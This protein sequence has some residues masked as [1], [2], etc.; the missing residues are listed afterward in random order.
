DARSR[1]V[2]GVAR[3]AGAP[4][5]RPATPADL[6]GLP[7]T[8]RRDAEPSQF[9]NGTKTA[10]R[11]LHTSAAPSE[12]DQWTPQHCRRGRRPWESAPQLDVTQNR[13]SSGTEPKQLRASSMPPRLLV[14][15]I[16]GRRRT[17]DEAGGPGRSAL[18]C[19]T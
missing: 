5:K 15:V 14:N 4:F 19:S 10:P 6:R 9:R 3:K 2:S 12:Q 17:A 7:Y 8:A 16:S 13:R 18:H 1:S 11:V